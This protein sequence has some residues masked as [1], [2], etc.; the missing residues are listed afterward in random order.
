M[1]LCTIEFPQL[2]SQ[3]VEI[4]PGF[5]RSLKRSFIT[6]LESSMDYR[7]IL[8]ILTTDERLSELSL[9]PQQLLLL[10][11]N[12]IEISVL[13]SSKGPKYQLKINPRKQYNSK[14]TVSQVVRI[15]EFDYKAGWILNIVHKYSTKLVQYWKSYKKSK[16]KQFK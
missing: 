12:S 6:D 10:I 3:E 4:L 9:T 14:I 7:K 1:L 15:I 13:Y 8:R 2:E 5:V 11:K 16:L